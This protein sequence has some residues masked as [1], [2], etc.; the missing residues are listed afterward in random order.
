MQWHDLAFYSGP[1]YENLRQL[2]VSADSDNAEQYFKELDLRFVINLSLEEG[3]KEI[4]LCE[5]GSKIMVTPENVHE[6]VELYAMQKM[7]GCMQK[8]LD[9]SFN[10]FLLENK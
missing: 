9:V 7:Y 1:L 5:D 3:G 2:I 8:P 10:S 6:Y 4:E